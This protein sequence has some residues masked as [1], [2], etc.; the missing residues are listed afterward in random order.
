MNAAKYLTAVA[1]AACIAVS[2]IGCSG[3]SGGS[4]ITTTKPPS[5]S[6]ISDIA[7]TGALD[8]HAAKASDVYDFTLHCDSGTFK[9]GGSYAFDTGVAFDVIEELDGRMR[10]SNTFGDCGSDPWLS[11]QLCK[12]R[13]GSDRLVGDRS[14]VADLHLDS[15]QFPVSA[16]LL[17]P[18]LRVDLKK[19]LDGFLADAAAKDPCSPA[20][21]AV[22]IQNPWEGQL[23]RASVPVVVRRVNESCD[24]DAQKFDLQWQWLPPVGDSQAGWQDRDVI[25]T[26]DRTGSRISPTDLAMGTWRVRARLSGH[27]Q[28]PWSDWVS[29]AVARPAQ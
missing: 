4:R 27:P 24:R 15:T 11:G 1:V 2:F 21:L 8:P 3:S 14:L 5:C 6:S 20:N 13:P 29:F 9:V 18:E 26:L 17:T 16:A 10:V 19:A 22:V 7:A 23:Y 12:R 25:A 28:A